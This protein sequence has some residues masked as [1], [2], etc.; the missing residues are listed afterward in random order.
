MTTSPLTTG[1]AS[2]GSAFPASGAGA[3]SAVVAAREEA[4]AL[5]AALT[6]AR[7]RNVDGATA[8][9]E[10][11]LFRFYLPVAR[12]LGDGAVRRSV[13]ADT[14]RHAAEVGLAQAVL[15]WPGADD[16]F[17]RYAS[18]CITNVLRHVPAV[19]PD[20]PHPLA[21]LPA[22]AGRSG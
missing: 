6:Q 13:P 17:L 2:P 20:R 11:A 19:T 4:Q 22:P 18:R 21:P 14:A 12:A 8:A 16:G 15:S 9:A 3:D 7:T 5:W 1:A 10:D